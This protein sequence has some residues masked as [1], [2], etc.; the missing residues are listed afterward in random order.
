MDATMTYKCPNCGGTLVWNSKKQQMVCEYCDT[1]FTEEQI[2]EIEKLNTEKASESSMNWDTYDDQS[3]ESK[4]GSSMKVHICQ[5]C[6][7]EII[8]D[9]NSVATECV[10]CGSPTIMTENIEGVNKPDY[11]IPFKLDKKAAKEALKN[12]YKG[13]R[14]LPNSF[15]SE[16]HIDKITGLYVPFWLFDCKANGHLTFDA[17]RTHIWSDARYDYTKTDHYA[18]TREGTMEFERIPADGSSKMDDNYMDAVE[19][20]NY[21][22]LTEFQPSYLAGYF[23]DKYDVSSQDCIPRANNRVTNS[24]VQALTQT[25]IGYN[26]TVPTSQNIQ[27][28]NGKVHYAMLPVWM[29]NTKYNDK[30]YNFAMNGQSGKLVGELPTDMKKFWM[31]FAGISAVAFLIAQIF[32][33]LI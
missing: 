17:T 27:V 4:M 33:F 25:V 14:L 23:A 20:F 18:V 3:A 32:V 2:N 8:G 7:G 13:K 5:S 16:N 1:A 26:T 22:D 9:E 6:G 29:L 24:T 15:A 30:L 19:P 10:Y 31:Y 12:F 21:Q 11:V 28:D